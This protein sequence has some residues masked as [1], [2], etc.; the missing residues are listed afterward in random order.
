[1]LPVHRTLIVSMSELLIRTQMVHPWDLPQGPERQELLS[2]F[3][4]T[5]VHFHQ[6][7][8]DAVRP[9]YPAV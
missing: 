4:E 6:P 9:A 8:V 2:L 1:M 7:A 3:K 5:A